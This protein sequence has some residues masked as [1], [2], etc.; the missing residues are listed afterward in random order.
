MRGVRV[1][2]DCRQLSSPIGRRFLRILTAQWTRKE[3]HAS[4]L[5]FSP[6][7]ADI[8]AMFTLRCALVAPLF[9]AALLGDFPGR[10]PNSTLQLPANPP[11]QGYSVVAAFPG[12]SFAAP[13]AIV[14]PPDETNRL[15]IVEKAGRIQVI[16]NLANPVL[17]TFLDIRTRVN[18]MSEGG[19]LGLAFHPGYLTNR[20][21]FVFY[22]LD[23]VTAAGSGFHNRVARFEIDPLDPHRALPDSELP[24]ITQ[25]DQAGNH[26]AGDVH[27]GP[28]GYLYVSL[29]DEGGGGDQYRN[30]RVINRD[31]FCAILRLDVDRRPGNLAPNPHPAATANYAI[32]MDNPFIGA[33]TFNGVTIDPDTVRTEFWAVGLRNPWRFS[34]DPATGWLYCGDVGQGVWEEIN[35]ISRGGDY[36]WN[37]L[38]GNHPYSGTPP[39]GVVLVPPILEYPHTGEAQYR[40]NSVTGGVVYRGN[41]L[42]QLYGDYVF[43]DYGSGNLW[44]L[45]YDG[46]EV[47]NW[48]RLASGSGIVAFGIDPSNGDILF[49][50]ISAG[51]IRRLDYNNNPTGDPLPPTLSATGAYADLATLTPHPGIVPYAVNAPFWSDGATKT[52]WFSIP[53]TNQFIN[54]NPAEPWRFPIGTV[55]IKHFELELTNGVPASARRLET[56]FLVRNDD[57]VYGVTY[58]WNEAQT[59]A[60]LVTEAGL[61]EVIPVYADGA[62]QPQTWRYPSRGECLACHTAVAGHALGFDTFQLNRDQ[63]FDTVRTN[64]ILGLSHMGYFQEPVLE[65]SSLRKH[66]A[67]ED[68]SATVQDRVRSYLTVN[69]VQCHQPGGT[70][71]GL[72][73]ARFTTPLADAGLIDGPLVFDAGDPAQ[74]VI[75]PGSLET[76][77]LLRRISRL[78]TGQMPPLAT[79]KLNATA[80]ELLTAWI[81]SGIAPEFREIHLD[82]QG[83]VALDFVGLPNQPYRVEFSPDLADWRFLG[84]TITDADGLGHSED[85]DPE[86]EAHRFYRVRDGSR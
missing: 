13:V 33:T 20:Q 5:D 70:A 77:M 16:T 8:P 50:E 43:A 46:T 75:T 59:D 73:D 86:P 65:V 12:L 71:R 52:R 85:P 31:F 2:T 34:F 36:G 7:R 44:A 42:S 38:E 35:I 3:S 10:I 37:Y 82:P 9:G 78:G 26:N 69:C 11:S 62:I 67:P 6:H 60:L 1:R 64:Q 14:S 29:G 39:T 18:P 66:V 74:R 4:A 68:P 84:E 19:L 58:R 22:T 41:R 83:T 30:S 27:F 45:R 54:F 48:R 72:W 15:F 17:S 81:A 21:F 25:Y 47:S 79:H 53:D 57:G 55:W 28:D 61:D 56:R 63:L 76:S 80:I 49:A 51:R 32:P 24:L 23:T 40:G